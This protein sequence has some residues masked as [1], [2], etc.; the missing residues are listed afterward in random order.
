MT[1]ERLSVYATGP[2]ASVY[3]QHREEREEHVCVR[4]DELA[5]HQRGDEVRVHGERHHLQQGHGE[6]HLQHGEITPHTVRLLR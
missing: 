6:I 4:E 3:L 5:A 2:A 1:A